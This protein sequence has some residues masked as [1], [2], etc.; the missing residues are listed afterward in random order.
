MNFRFRRKIQTLLAVPLLLAL[1]IW[2]VIGEAAP[3]P[4]TTGTFP[5]LVSGN[6]YAGYLVSSNVGIVASVGALF[7][8]Q[9]SSCTTSNLTSNSSALSMQ[10]NSGLTPVL[11]SGT[12][13]DQTQSTFTS[14][15]ATVQSS[16]TINGL[17]MF[18]GLV[19]ADTIQSTASSTAD[20][21]TASSSGGATFV[22]LVVGGNSITASPAPNTYLTLSGVGSITLNRQVT[23]TTYPSSSMSVWAM[24]VHVTVANNIFG[25]PVGSTLYV[26]EAS[27]N[28]QALS[29]PH[30]VGALSYALEAN[31][32][33]GPGAAQSGPWAQAVVGC[34]GG[35][36]TVTLASVSVPNVG[37]VGSMVDTASGQITSSPSRG[38]AQA[39]STD[40]QVSLL[41]GLITA[42]TVAS[43]ASAA[44][45][46]SN[47]GT[48]SGSTTLTTAT[49][50]GLPVSVNP[51]PNTTINLPGIGRV[52]LNE[53]SSSITASQASMHVNAIHVYVTLANLL[54]LPVGAQII[55][56]HSE[57]T[58]TRF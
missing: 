9:L 31:G 21:S 1:L 15:N 13:A 46:G 32:L 28:V 52:V 8:S 25:L 23:S 3:T 19:T 17:T 49:V 56:G 14:T 33:A 30:T 45:K 55:V 6:A 18:N 5:A 58:A 42:T 2:P 24:V 50:L 29:S 54:G 37:S 51:A 40:Q 44:I 47:T 12:L 20:A 7:V 22:N 57:A 38:A 35:N 41:G 43:S 48:T 39:S 34:G 27:S 11:N 26:G 10:I 4:Q 53:Q 36:V 16:S